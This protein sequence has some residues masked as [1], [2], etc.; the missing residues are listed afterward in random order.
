MESAGSE[1]VTLCHSMEEAK[2]AFNKIMNKINVLGVRNEAVL[3]QEYLE[4]TEYIVDT[5]SCN[6]KHKVVA[7]WEYDKRPVNGG[8]FVYFGVHFRPVVGKIKEL[9]DYQLKV[10]DALGFTHGP[11]HGEVKFCKGA[12][13]LIE[14]GARCHGGEGFS[15]Q[16]AR[17]CAGYSQIDAVIHAMVD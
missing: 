3:V 9:V 11:G 1:D 16:L 2:A 5:V 14:V 4:G 12:P 8:G 7:V 15:M 6:G 17:K 10:L 13:V